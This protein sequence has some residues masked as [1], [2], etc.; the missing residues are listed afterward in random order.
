MVCKV[1][2]GLVALLANV[3][4][5]YE[6]SNKNLLHICFTKVRFQIS[7]GHISVNRALSIIIRAQSTLCQR[8]NEIWTQG[9]ML[10]NSHLKQLH[11]V[12]I[13]RILYLLS[14]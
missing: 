4:L 9:L 11:L 1:L 5:A 14:L 13:D 6:T 10:L 2:F 12:T 3:L 8:K 7:L